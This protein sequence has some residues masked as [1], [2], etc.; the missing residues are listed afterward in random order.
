MKK[1]TK[2]VKV[3][4]EKEITRTDFETRQ[5]EF[6]CPKADSKEFNEFGWLFHCQGKPSL[7]IL[8][9]DKSFDFGQVAAWVETVLEPDPNNA[10]VLDSEDEPEEEEATTEDDDNAP[11]PEPEDDSEG[12]EEKEVALEF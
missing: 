5:I 8:I 6:I 4:P 2:V 7:H 12:E 1:P 10:L 11:D 3:A 9:V